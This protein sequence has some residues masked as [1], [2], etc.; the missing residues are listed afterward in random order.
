MENNFKIL[1]FGDNCPHDII[2]LDNQ[3]IKMK[4]ISKEEK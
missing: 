4:M 1:D 2:N 3:S